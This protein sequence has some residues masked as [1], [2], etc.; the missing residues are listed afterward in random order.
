MNRAAVTQFPILYMLDR[1]AKSETFIQREI[2]QLHR[3]NWP[4]HV[5]FLQGGTNPLK[6]S[7]FACPSGYRTRLL[8]VALKRVCLEFIHHPLDALRLLRRIPQAGSM[9]QELLEYNGEL[10]HAHFA[11]MTALLASVV[12]EAMN[13]PWTCSVHA[14]DVFTVSRENLFRRIGSAAGICACSELAAQAV[15]DAGVPE[16]KVVMIHHGLHMND[17]S[18]DTIQPDG[19]I[20]TACRLE[21]KK[22]LDVL[23]KACALIK[24]EGLTFSC[25]IAGSGPMSESLKKTRIRLGLMDTVDLIGWQSQ[26]ETRSLLMDSTVL[27]LPSRVMP[28]GDR[29]GIANILLEAMAIGTPVVTTTAGAAT[30]VIENGVNGWIVP[31]DDPVA[32]AAALR[33]TLEA[34]RECITVASNARRTIEQNFDEYKNIRQLERFFQANRLGAERS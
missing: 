12:A 23:L 14:K 9:V 22:G 27:A 16:E 32:L 34:R 30:E 21:P 25:I 19:I 29:D 8:K 4:V 17:Y 10:I 5:C 28:N 20:F 26:E 15:R 2:E 6:F 31:P 18:Y 24:E 13:I 11:G 7:F 1:P 33:H 3:K